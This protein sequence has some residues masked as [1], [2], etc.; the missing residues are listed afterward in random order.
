MIP[1]NGVMDSTE[2]DSNTT[3]AKFISY[4]AGEIGIKRKELKLAYKFSTMP[5]KEPPK[6]L[7]RPEHLHALFSEAVIILRERQKSKLKAKSKKFQVLLVDLDAKARSRG[8]GKGA[9]GVCYL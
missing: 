6:H 9:I 8:K 2:F 7:S 1:I 3:W 5:V 4:V